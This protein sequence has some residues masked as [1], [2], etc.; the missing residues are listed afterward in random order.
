MKLRRHFS[1]LLGFA[2]AIAVPTPSLALDAKSIVDTQHQIARRPL[3]RSNQGSEVY[4]AIV[5]WARH[6]LTRRPAESIVLTP[7]STLDAPRFVSCGDKP[8]AAIFDSHEMMIWNLG[9]RAS[10]GEPR[11]EQ[12]WKEWHESGAAEAVPGAVAA[13][14]ELRALGITVIFISNRP[15]SEAD[16]AVKSIKEAGLGDVTLGT[17]L[18]LQDG[19]SPKKDKRRLSIADR[20]CVISMA[21]QLTVDFSDLFIVEVPKSKAIVTVRD[22]LAQIEATKPIPQ[23][24]WMATLIGRGWFPLPSPISIYAADL[25]E[26][27][28]N[29]D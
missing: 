16:A 7:D 14:N 21:G 20:Y 25:K 15:T 6:Q 11:D 24:Q 29:G 2:C 12:A 8:F 5:D 4:R 27:L 13:L 17:T 3:F 18:L 10:A 26:S 1:T 23:P 9:Q 19:W 28:R 22:A